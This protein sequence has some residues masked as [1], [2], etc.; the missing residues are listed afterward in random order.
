MLAIAIVIVIFLCLILPYDQLRPLISPGNNWMQMRSLPVPEFWHRFETL[1]RFL[2][3]Q[4]CHNVISSVD[5]CPGKTLM[6]GQALGQ[7]E[8]E[9]ERD[10]GGGVFSSCLRS[11]LTVSSSHLSMLTTIWSYYLSCCDRFM[12][13]VLDAHWGCFR[14]EWREVC[15]GHMKLLMGCW[16]SFGGGCER[17]IRK[18]IFMI[19]TSGEWKGN[20][21]RERWGMTNIPDLTQTRDVMVYDSKPICYQGVISSLIHT[22]R[23][24][25]SK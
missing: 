25:F 12:C 23:V 14:V 19:A 11:P 15:A 4:P 24:L 7:R 20:K 6:W 17:K 21:C 2:F 1:C 16:C 10:S 13:D 22:V 3:L 18:S 9:R 5:S 8:R